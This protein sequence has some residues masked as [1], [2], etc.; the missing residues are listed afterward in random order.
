LVL[1]IV[2]ESASNQIGVFIG[3][4]LVLV[5]IWFFYGWLKSKGSDTIENK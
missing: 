4:A 3:S 1:P 5:V 2:G